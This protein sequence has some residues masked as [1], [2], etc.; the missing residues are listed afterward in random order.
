MLQAHVQ[1]REVFFFFFEGRTL[2]PCHEHVGS[3]ATSARYKIPAVG[4]EVVVGRAVP[5]DA[6]VS[7]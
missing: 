1:K 4:L 3:L 6:L 2:A 5:Q 7:A